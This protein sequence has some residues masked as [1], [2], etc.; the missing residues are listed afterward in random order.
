[1]SELVSGFNVEY[2]RGGFALINFLA[3]YAYDRFIDD[4]CKGDFDALQRPNHAVPDRGSLLRK[5]SCTTY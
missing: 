2:R 4:M 5:L 3:E 1:M